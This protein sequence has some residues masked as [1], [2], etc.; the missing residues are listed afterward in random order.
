MV[1]TDF[2][3]RAEG[4]GHSSGTDWLLNGCFCSYIGLGAGSL[5]DV[6]YLFTIFLLPV[7]TLNRIFQDILKDY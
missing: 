2:N 6:Y 4:S 1:G 7:D 5:R 3:V